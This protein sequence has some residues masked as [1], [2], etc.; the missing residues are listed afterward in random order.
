MVAFQMKSIDNAFI[1]TIQEEFEVKIIIK[2]EHKKPRA[3]ELYGHGTPFRHRVEKNKKKYDR[4][5]DKRAVNW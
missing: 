5:R 1:E 3:T 4:S 2:N